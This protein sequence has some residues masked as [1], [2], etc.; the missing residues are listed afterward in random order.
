M[1]KFLNKKIPEFL[2]YTVIIVLSAASA[3]L[4]CLQYLKLNSEQPD[5][6]KTEI[7]QNKELKPGATKL[8]Y[9]PELFLVSDEKI[10]EYLGG[11]YC[12]ILREDVSGDGIYAKKLVQNQPALFVSVCSVSSGCSRGAT[13]T[14]YSVD[15]TSGKISTAWWSNVYLL[16]AGDPLQHALSPVTYMK[17]KI[18]FEDQDSDGDF[19]IVQDITEM[20]CRP[21]CQ[22]TA[23]C[24]SETDYCA[25]TNIISSEDYQKKFKWD[26]KRGA[27]LQI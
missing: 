9:V 1:F 6:S 12:G 18:N 14:I 13:M 4:I 21:E 16:A 10:L 5:F 17:S 3:V 11:S 19:E 25:G 7:F 27:F 20:S 22:K 2:A 26:E 24:C 8:G 23:E 15:R